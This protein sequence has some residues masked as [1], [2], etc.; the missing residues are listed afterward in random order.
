MEK[1]IILRIEL[2]PSAKASLGV[3]CDRTGMTQVAMLSRVVEWYALQPEAIQ[4]IV[5]GHIPKDVQHD[6]ARAMLK[7]L[8][9]RQSK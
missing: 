4:R 7:K 2:T 3:V 8:A 6:V 1:R 9:Q 5:V